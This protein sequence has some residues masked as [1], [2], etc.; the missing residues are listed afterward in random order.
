MKSN[1]IE[2][3]VSRFSQGWLTLPELNP[4]F[5]KI[6]QRDTAQPSFE[7]D[8]SVYRVHGYL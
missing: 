2:R 8:M 1:K 6:F 7:A 4:S 3:R 5:N